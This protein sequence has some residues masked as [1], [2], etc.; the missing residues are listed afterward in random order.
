LYVG[1]GHMVNIINLSDR[2]ATSKALVDKD[3]EIVAM[4]QQAWNII[5]WATNWYDSRQYY[6]NGVDAVA[7]EV[8]EWKGLIIQSACGTE[9]IS[10]VLTTSW[11]TSWTVEWYEYRLYAVSW[12]QRNLIA[13]K[14]FQYWSWD[15]LEAPHYNENKK[16]DF[17]DVTNDKGM[18]V[19]LDSLYIPWCDGAYKYWYDV[20]W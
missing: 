8:I 19:F 11:A 6:R 15:Y 9:T 13:S 1:C 14:L 4:N 20:P 3:F 18:I 10:Y 12:Y 16:F 17:N 2:W 7:T 5:I